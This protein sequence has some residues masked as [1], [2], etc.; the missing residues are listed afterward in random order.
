M[1]VN[2]SIGQFHFSWQKK[3]VLFFFKTTIKNKTCL[4][5]KSICENSW[6]RRMTPKFNKKCQVENFGPEKLSEEQDGNC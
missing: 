4:L 1:S 5:P 6:I 2:S 3:A